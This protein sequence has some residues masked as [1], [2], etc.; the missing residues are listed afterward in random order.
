MIQIT[1]LDAF[2]GVALILVSMGIAWGS[3]KN[4]VSSIRNL[5]HNNVIPDLKDLRERFVVVE[6]RVE[7]LWR[8]RGAP[9]LQKT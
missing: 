7:G 1:D 6:D 4:E 3:L 9:T 2:L 5:L 8:D